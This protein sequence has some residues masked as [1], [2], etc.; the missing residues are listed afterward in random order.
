ILCLHVGR[1]RVSPADALAGTG[2]SWPELLVEERF[3]PFDAARALILNAKRLT[4]RPDLGLEWGFETETSVHGL[5]GAGAVTSRSVSDAVRV[6]ARYRSL[7]SRATTYELVSAGEGATLVMRETFDLGDVRSFILEAQA[8]SLE[9]ILT[10]V[11]G[12]PLADCEY[13]FPYPAPSWC[14]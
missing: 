3:V 2:L 12:H 10:T 6:A 9:R 14:S 11:A 4:G 13:M 5:Q 8:T 1:Y 7:R